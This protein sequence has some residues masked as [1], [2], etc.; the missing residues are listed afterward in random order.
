MTEL[1]PHT[2]MKTYSA[3]WTDFQLTANA[4][5][6]FISL[7]QTESMFQAV[8]SLPGAPPPPPIITY[9]T[10]IKSMDTFN[11][12]GSIIGNNG[13]LDTEIT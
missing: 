8:A 3:S 13:S 5:I 10:E 11:Y 7:G 2:L 6:S 4:V 9:N 12:L 1:L